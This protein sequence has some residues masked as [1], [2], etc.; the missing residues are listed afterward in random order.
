MNLLVERQ[1][2]RVARGLELRFRRIDRWDFYA[3][4]GIDHV[5]D[6]AQRVP[7]FF[8]GLFE[9]MLRQLRQR[10]GRKMRRDRVILQLRGELVSNLLVNRVDDLLTC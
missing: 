7:L 6:K 1:F 2:H 10:F 4:A 8:L 3:S 9:K 5:F